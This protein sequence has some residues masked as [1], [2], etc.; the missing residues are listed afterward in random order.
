MAE[1]GHASKMISS[2]KFLPRPV[3]DESAAALVM[4]DLVDGD[5]VLIEETPVRQ[6]TDDTMPSVPAVI[7]PGAPKGHRLQKKLLARVALQHRSLFVVSGRNRVRVF[8]FDLVHHRAFEALVIILIFANCIFLALDDPTVAQADQPDYLRQMEL[9]FTCAFAFEMCLKV[10]AMGFLLHPGSY[11]RNGWNQLDFFIV[12]MSFL[13]FLPF[14]DNYSAIRTLRVLRPLRSI[15]GIQGLKNIVN[16]LLGSVKKLVNVLALVAFLLFIFGILGVQLWKGRFRYRCQLAVDENRTSCDGRAGCGQSVYIPGV[17][18]HVEHEVERFCRRGASRSMGVNVFGRPCDEG[19]VCVETDS[20]PNFNFTRFDNFL[21]AF[22]SIFQCLTM[23]G[24]VDIMYIVQDTWSSLGVVYFLLLILLGSFLILNLALAV[25]NEEFDRIREEAENER[26]RCVHNALLAAEEQLEIERGLVQ[27]CPR[28]EDSAADSFPPPISL[29]LPGASS[30]AA[31]ALPCDMEKRKKVQITSPREL[32]RPTGRNARK[33]S[34]AH[35]NKYAAAWLQLRWVCFAVVTHSLFQPFI[36]LCITVNTCLL[37]MEHHGQPEWLTQLLRTANIVLT[38]IFTLEMLLKLMAS[39]FRGYIEDRFNVLD[40]TVVILSLLELVFEGLAMPS[41]T[42][43]RAFRLLRVFKLLK[44]FPELRRLIQVI[45]HAVSDTGYLNLIILLYLF[46]AALVGMQFFGGKFDFPDREEPRATFNSFGYSFLTVFQV[47]T[48]DDWVLVMWDAMLAQSPASALYFIVLVICGDFLILNLFLAIL[49]GSFGVHASE[50]GFADDASD[51]DSDEP[52]PPEGPTKEERRWSALVTDHMMLRGMLSDSTIEDQPHTGRRTTIQKDLPRTVTMASRIRRGSSAMRRPMHSPRVRA[53]NNSTEMTNSHSSGGVDDVMEMVSHRSSVNSFGHSVCTDEDVERE[54]TGLSMCRSMRTLAR[55]GSCATTPRRRLEM[56]T[57]VRVFAQQRARKGSATSSNLPVSLHR[58]H[59][60]EPSDVMLCERCGEPLFDEFLPTDAEAIMVHQR[61]CPLIRLRKLRERTLYDVQLLVHVLRQRGP[62]SRESL[63]SVLSLLWEVGLMLD[64]KVS[65]LEEA[66]AEMREPAADSAAKVEHALTAWISNPMRFD[67]Y[68]AEAEPYCDPGDVQAEA[69]QQSVMLMD[70]WSGVAAI[71]VR[72]QRAVSLRLR[73]EILG[74]ALVTFTGSQLPPVRRTNGGDSL[75]LF[76]PRNPI[77]VMAYS[78]VKHAAFNN[79]ILVCICLSSMTL[80]LE[81][82]RVKPGD[83]TETLLQFGNWIFTGIFLA[84]MILKVI[85]FGLVFGRS[86]PDPPYL[87]DSWNVMDGFIVIASVLSVILQ[88]LNL[89][90]L[91]V[92]LTF[93][94]L[95]PLRVI[96]RNRGLRMVVI[97]LIQSIGSIGNVAL[98]SFIVFLVF[99]ILGVQFFAGKLHH[100]TDTLVL[101]RLSCRGWFVGSAGWEQRRW[102]NRRPQHY[103]DL[104]ASLLTLF[105]ISTLE[106]WS[107]IMWHAVDGVSTD[108]AQQKNAEPTSAI[109][110]VSFVVVGAFFILNLFVGVVIHHYNEVKTKEDGLHFLTGDQKLW[111]ETQRMMLNFTPAVKMQPRGGDRMLRLYHFAKGHNFEMFIGVCILLNVLQMT[112]QRDDESGE[113]AAVSS[114]VDFSFGTLFFLEFALKFLAFGITYFRDAWNRFDFFLVSVWVVSTFLDFF[115]NAG[116]P[117]NASVLRMLRIFRIMRIMRLVKA[118][119]DVRILLET[120]WYSLPSI[121]NIGGFL[122]LL[123]FIYAVLGVNVFA[124]VRR[125][126]TAS[127]LTYHANFESF[128]N[129]LLLLFRMVTGE[130]WNQVMHD[131]MVAPPDCNTSVRK[132]GLTV[133]ECGLDWEA[134]LYYISFLLVAGF[135]LTNLF[136]AIILDN[137]ATT[138]EIEKSDLRMQDLHR[139]TEIWSD[140][141]PDGTL[142]IPTQQLPRLLEKLGRPLGISNRTSRIEIL[143]RNRS[144]CIPEH[145]GVIHFIETLIPLARQVMNANWDSQLDHKDLRAQ[146]ESWRLSFPDIN[147]LRVLRV[148]QRRATTDHYFAASYIAAAYRRSSAKVEVLRRRE[149][150]FGPRFLWLEARIAAVPPTDVAA[151]WKLQRAAVLTW[152]RSHG[153]STATQRELLSQPPPLALQLC[154]ELQ[155]AKQLTEIYVTQRKEEIVA[156]HVSQ[157]RLDSP[158]SSSGHLPDNGVR[159]QRRKM[160]RQMSGK[161]A[162]KTKGWF[163]R[164]DR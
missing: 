105:E 134:P 67:P 20:N 133:S 97:T 69:I 112:T 41:F 89:G 78:T 84:E 135:V 90:I 141:D 128:P 137:F 10:F 9:F 1:G 156:A 107:Q 153:L 37:A 53:R 39:G 155:A 151:T 43:F 91:K 62:P 152:A 102:I 162:S 92:F 25:I 48:R 12:T 52:P 82:P 86:D 26:W 164:R 131:T 54:P 101:H 94:A 122:L 11:L 44:N 125:G 74:R 93:R 47:L 87:L 49:I 30:P 154:R 66:A 72:E 160:L 83:T 38:V 56:D 136:V 70:E 85:A 140:F 148:R 158:V 63:E 113:F 16:G 100:C 108:E 129:A 3:E 28:R 79:F 21:W 138:M 19:Y 5:R 68:I 118:A 71:I 103:D 142:V 145:G 33:A 123:F 24:W 65:E 146:E 23:E 124:N 32:R 80:V 7:S 147:Q 106:M 143:A 157:W 17:P 117:V 13:A 119:G 40:G 15:N 159:R 132:G 96:S 36:I 55:H 35:R 109:F 144:Y 73:E 88:G 120:V 18:I 111:I 58:A 114:W 14:L 126:D 77:R 95:R 46:I 51:D 139:F 27:A 31:T 76:G 115:Q 116:V 57:A 60:L 127:G 4:E 121:A 34:A 29:M 22:L 6:H 149:E 150:F 163:Q 42:V 59:S 161:F 64:S 50:G 61:L 81:N 104:R 2:P 110:F 130:N 8:V 75:G 98:I 99:G 45:L